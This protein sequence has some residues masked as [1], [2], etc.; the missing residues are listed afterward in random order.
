MHCSICMGQMLVNFGKDALFAEGDVVTVES[1]LLEIVPAFEVWERY[2]C[3]SCKN[4]HYKIKLLETASGV[5]MPQ[6]IICPERR[7]TRLEN[8]SVC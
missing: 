8:S 2:I 1:K 4:V 7:L 5:S 3:L 6:E